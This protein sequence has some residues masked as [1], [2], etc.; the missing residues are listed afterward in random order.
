MVDREPLP[1]WCEGR[2]TLMGDAAH[3]T[4]PVGS[5]GGS[6]GIVDARVFGAA[7]LSHGI[8]PE[9][10]QAYEDELLPQTTKVTLANR[11]SGPGAIM[12]LVEDRSGGVFEHIEDVV[13]KAELAE[14]ATTY[15]AIAGFAIEALN[16]RPPS[17]P[18]GARLGD[19]T[20]A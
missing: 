1:R 14:H 16:A 4:Y 8:G 17:I 19:Q 3:L 12:Q 2:A 5:S 10:L 18:A 15:K 13:A 7:L 11:G 6:Q 20:S 9:A